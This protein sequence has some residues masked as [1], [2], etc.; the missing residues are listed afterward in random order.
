MIVTKEFR[1]DQYNNVYD[2]NGVFYCVWSE[3][4]KD[5]QKIVKQNDFSAK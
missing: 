2:S 3:L 4:T 5:E 1:V